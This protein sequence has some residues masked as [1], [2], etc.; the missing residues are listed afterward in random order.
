MSEF[1]GIGRVIPGDR[2]KE[3]PRRRLPEREF[4]EDVEAD[5]PEDEGTGAETDETEGLPEDVLRERRKGR[6]IGPPAENEEGQIID[7]LA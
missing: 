3:R 4:E 5:E 6:E 7:I 2:P 1:E